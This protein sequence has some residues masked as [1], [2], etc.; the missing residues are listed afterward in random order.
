MTLALSPFAPSGA[1]VVSSRCPAMIAFGLERMNALI[2]NRGGLYL[3]YYRRKAVVG[4]TSYRGAFF[5][6]L[7][8]FFPSLF[9]SP[10]LSPSL[11]LMAAGR[12]LSAIVHAFLGVVVQG[13]CRRGSASDTREVWYFEGRVPS[14]TGSWPWFGECCLLVERCERRGICPCSFATFH[15]RYT[16]TEDQE[17]WRNQYIRASSLDVF[18][19]LAIH[20]LLC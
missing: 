7:F 4:E 15:R 17:L 9:F 1:P 11:R 6:P 19:P 10:F 18:T 13:C 20:L 5:V 8:P 12:W 16:P 14:R 3:T 2:S